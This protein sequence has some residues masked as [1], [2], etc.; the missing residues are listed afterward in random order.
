HVDLKDAAESIDECK[1]EV[2]RL[3][4]ILNQFLKALRP[5]KLSFCPTDLRVVLEES[6]N[7]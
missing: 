6:L 2:E 4:A 5:A 7:F 3:D 1:K